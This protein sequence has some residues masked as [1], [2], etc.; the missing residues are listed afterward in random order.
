MKIVS[1]LVDVCKFLLDLFIPET[2]I[3]FEL[4]KDFLYKRKPKDISYAALKYKN[5]EVKELIH[6]FKYNKNRSALEIC[7]ALLIKKIIGVSKKVDLQNSF[8]IPIP[9]SKFRKKKFGF[10]QCELLCK[11]ILKN[12]EIKKL[13]LVFMPDILIH[14]KEFDSQTK[15]N[16]IQR[17]RNSKNTFL[18]RNFEQVS[19]QKIILVDDVWTTGATLLDAKRSLRYAGFS[20][21]FCFTIAH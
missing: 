4:K 20:E 9:R 7:G 15:S 3:H 5:K 10:D 8:L 6:L 16:R 19:K 18:V 2:K 13:N 12:P 1:K 17:L 11:E 14:K 21:I